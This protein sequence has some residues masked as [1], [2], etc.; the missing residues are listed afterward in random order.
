MKIYNFSEKGFSLVELMTIVVVM[1]LLIVIAGSFSSRYSQRTNIDQITN[2]ILGDL[3]I[4]KLQAARDGI[5][6]RFS[7]SENADEDMIEIKRERGNSNRL[8]SS[9]TEVGSQQVKVESYVDITIVPTSPLVIRPDGSLMTFPPPDD[10][11]TESSCVIR[12]KDGAGYNRCGQVSITRL[13]HLNIIKGNW[14]GTECE[15]VTDG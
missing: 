2:S 7:I 13:G 5:E 11:L 4:T 10:D 8:S 9:W 12:P 3:Q 15:Q 1:S 14:N 6:Y